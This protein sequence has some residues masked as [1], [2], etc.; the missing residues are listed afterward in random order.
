MRAVLAMLLTASSIGAGPEIGQ[1]VAQVAAVERRLPWFWSPA[2]EGLTDIPYTYEALLTR[3]V[4]HNG[5]GVPGNPGTLA[6]WRTVKFE[7]IPLDF[8]AFMKCLAADGA[9]PCSSEWNQE[10]D[11]QAQRR[12]AL[13]AEDRARIE[14]AREERR[15]RRRK[16]WDEFPS[17]MRFQSASPNQLRFSPVR[18][19]SGGMLTAIEGVFTFEPSTFEITGMQYDLLRDLDEPFL[20]YPK[21]THFEVA[22]ARAADRHYLPER[23][24]VRQRAVKSGNMEERITDLSNFRR[25]ASE[26]KIEFGDPKEVKK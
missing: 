22:L 18:K 26:S 24:L 7:R 14:A 6:G 20:R 4:T 5:K 10:F 25:F 16:F 9:S 15:E 2:T 17:A 3:R 11:R 1:T 19:A 13:A 21:G 8:G 12:E 23:V